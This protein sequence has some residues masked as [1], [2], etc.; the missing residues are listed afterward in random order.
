MS[1]KYST[2]DEF[3]ADLNLIWDNCLLFNNEASD[4][5]RQANQMKSIT[6][7]LIKKMKLYQA[8]STPEVFKEAES[9]DSDFGLLID[10]ALYVR[11]D[12]KVR[13]AEILK[14]CTR[15]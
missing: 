8:Q 13:F 15:E 5:C 4:I 2:V 10:P 9:D 11:Y 6:L 12:D 3:C 1:N 14:N 7:L